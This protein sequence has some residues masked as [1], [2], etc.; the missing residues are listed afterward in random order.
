MNIRTTEIA[1]LG[2]GAAILGA[3]IP[4]GLGLALVLGMAA[5]AVA[6]SP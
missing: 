3:R 4:L 1:D 6:W 2:R 5:L